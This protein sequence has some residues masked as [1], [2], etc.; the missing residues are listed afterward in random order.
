MNDADWVGIENEA[1]S[2][3]SRYIQ[4]DTTNPP[5]NE[6]EG[7]EFLGDWLS[8]ESIPATMYHPVP[9]RANL[10]AVLKGDGSRSPVLLL[11]HID[12]VPAAGERWSRDPFGGVVEDGHVWG[13]GAIDNKSLGVMHLMAFALLRRQSVRLKRDVMM[14]AVSDE[15]MGGAVGSKWMIDN[16]WDDIRSEYLWDEGGVGTLGIVGDRPVFAVSVSEK[17]SVV[18]ILRAG[19]AGGHGSMAANAPVERLLAALECLRG[20]SGSVE[21]GPVTIE[22]LTRLSKTQSFPAS[23]LMRNASRPWGRPLVVGKLSA[24]PS[25]DAM[26]RDTIRVTMLRAGDSANV[27]P[28]IAEAVLDVRL[29]PGTDQ[30]GFLQL[31]RDVIDDETIEVQATEALTGGAASPSDSDFFR[32]L[33]QAV[34][35]SSPDAIVTPIQT[36]VA[37]DS[38]FFR[39]RGVKAYGINPGIFTQSEIETIHGVDERISLRNLGMGTRIVYESLLDLCG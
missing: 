28:D 5:G 11:H 26:L 31:V 25:I 14:L 16:H 38:R 22:F 18:V 1:A 19:G 20:W 13:R 30:G 3:L 17:R 10:L 15:E 39:Q 36:P 4:I 2:V 7:A 37:T 27:S 29:L 35:G 32:A 8:G 34:L 6:R 33:E 24:I 21:L 9:D 23:W 12:V